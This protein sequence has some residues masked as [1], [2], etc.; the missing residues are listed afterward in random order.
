[1]PVRTGAPLAELAATLD[2]ATDATEL[3]ER[4]DETAA[5]DE[6]AGLLDA[7]TDEAAGLDEAVPLQ[8]AAVSCAP[9]LPTPA[10]CASLSFTH[11][12]VTGA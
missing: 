5:T 1:M 3:D 8:A 11:C 9:F 6:L 7:A 4:L 10:N 2:G 12:G